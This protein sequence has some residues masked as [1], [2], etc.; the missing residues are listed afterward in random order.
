MLI[1][2]N[3]YFLAS[4]S[5]PELRSFPISQLKSIIQAGNHADS[6]VTNLYELLLSE[7][8]QHFSSPF[9]L[10]GEPVYAFSMDN[11]SYLQHYNTFRNLKIA[12]ED[13][14]SFT[15]RALQLHQTAA[16][17]FT[18]TKNQAA[19]IYFDLQRLDFV[20][21]YAAFEGKDSIYQA[22][23]QA[24]KTEFSG[25]PSWTE[26]VHKLAL[27]KMSEAAEYQPLNEETKI[28]RFKLQEAKNFVR[29]P[30]THFLKALVLIYADS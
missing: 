27:I 28:H 15:F 13:T 5:N 24:Y 2:S 23:L 3:K 6:L 9:T 25:I 8:I 1:I 12:T 26:I 14:L 21:Q 10:L 16:N 11:P 30:S 19:L 22:V 4:A 17:H 20:K 7:A 29:K 18:S